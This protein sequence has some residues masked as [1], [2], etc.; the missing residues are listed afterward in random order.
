MLSFS[1][2]QPPS[3]GETTI[4]AVVRTGGKQY[5]VSEGDVIEV[6]KLSDGSGTIRLTPLLVVDDEGKAR[7]GGEISGASVTAKVVGE[8]KGPKLKIFKY[9]SKSRYR[10]NLGHRQRYSRLEISQIKLSKGRSS[11]SKKS[12][13][14]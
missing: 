7:T 13:E 10:R 2:W 1:A 8:S 3:R 9:R 5:K 6:E 14:S 11:R 4:Y 12:E